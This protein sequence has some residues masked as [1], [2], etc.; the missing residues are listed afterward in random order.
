MAS[1]PG[2][3]MQKAASMGGQ[4]KDNSGGCRLACVQVPPGFV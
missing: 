3:R 4:M 1:E 2:G